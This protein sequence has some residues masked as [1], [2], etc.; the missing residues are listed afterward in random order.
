MRNLNENEI[1]VISGGSV[2]W[3]AWIDGYNCDKCR[4]LAGSVITFS[5]LCSLM[6]NSSV[7]VHTAMQYAISSVLSDPE[8][9]HVA[10]KYCTLCRDE[11][12][13]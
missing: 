12:F 9:I 3:A 2:N 13:E 8:K 7:G 11:V 6:G 5:F 10:I 4:A 1:A